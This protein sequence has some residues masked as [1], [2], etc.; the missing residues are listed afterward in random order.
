M[1][2]LYNPSS[3]GGPTGMEPKTQAVERLIDALSPTIA[4]ELERVVME[5]RRAVEVELEQRFNAAV[6]QAETDRQA[7][8]EKAVLE[9]QDTVRRQ[10]TDELQSQF[11]KTIDDTSSNLKLSY[12]S[13]LQKAQVEL[14]KAQS[15][16]E[17]LQNDWNSDRVGLEHQVQQWRSLA[18]AQK[19][20]AE[21]NSQIEILMRWLSLAEP[22]GSS[23][24]VYTAKA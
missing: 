12:Q 13:E 24:A 5:T 14:I 2:R 20:L 15:D 21:A 19:Q 17:K 10:V 22:C 3:R 9:V 23:I 7:A 16:L 8:V 6:Q 11:S 18:E 1:A 4:A